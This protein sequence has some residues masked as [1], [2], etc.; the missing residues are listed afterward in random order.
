MVIDNTPSSPI[1]SDAPAEDQ[2]APMKAPMKVTLAMKQSIKPKAKAKVKATI[3]I[4][5]A[6]DIIKNSSRQSHFCEI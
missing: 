6:A 1:A 5:T 4:K 2:P 3:V